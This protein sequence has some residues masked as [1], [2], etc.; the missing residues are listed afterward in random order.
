MFL[1]PE[2]RLREL[3][4]SLQNRSAAASD[5]ETLRAADGRLECMIRLSSPHGPVSILRISNDAVTVT[6][7]SNGLHADAGESEI[8]D[9]LGVDLSTG[10]VW[11][12]VLCVSAD[13]LA[14]LLVKHMR[15]RIRDAD[16]EPEGVGE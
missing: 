16:P 15:R 13:E 2:D 6:T 7:Q 11:D 9:E 1:A 8:V 14:H 5:L 3:C 4:V 12:D 10:Y